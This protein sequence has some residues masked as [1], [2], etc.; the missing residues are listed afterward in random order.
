MPFIEHAIYRKLLS[1]A[2]CTVGKL[3]ISEKT[4]DPVEADSMAVFQGLKFK[5][6]RGKKRMQQYFGETVANSF[7]I[8]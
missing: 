4:L 5:G 2:R 1:W 6:G 3:S 8:S 7:D